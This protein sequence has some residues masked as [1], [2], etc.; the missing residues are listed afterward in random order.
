[1][2][3]EFVDKNVLIVNGKHIRML[4]YNFAEQ[5]FQI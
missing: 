2:A 1:M 3:L 4:F 5:S